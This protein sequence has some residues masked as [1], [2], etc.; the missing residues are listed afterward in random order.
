MRVIIRISSGA[1]LQRRREAGAVRKRSAGQSTTAVG[2]QRW[3]SGKRQFS[4]GSAASPQVRRVAEW[5][6][7]ATT[8]DRSKID[9]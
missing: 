5:F 3:P 2:S 1:E 9:V 4:A 8:L 7:P 6:N